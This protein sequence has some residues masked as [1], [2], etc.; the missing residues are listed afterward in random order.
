[1]TVIAIVGYLFLG[2]I[3]KRYALSLGHTAQGLEQAPF[4]VIGVFQHY[5]WYGYAILLFMLVMRWVIKRL[6]P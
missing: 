4:V 3:L 2:V 1:M 5:W 6:M